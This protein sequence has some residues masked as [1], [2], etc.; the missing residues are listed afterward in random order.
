MS[1]KFSLYEDLT[2]M[3][4]IQFFGGIY[5]LPDKQLKQKSNELIETLGLKNEAKK[6]VGSLPLA[7]NK[8]WLFQ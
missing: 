8:N 4:N 1:Q 7:G 6:L 5:G 3:E 2:V